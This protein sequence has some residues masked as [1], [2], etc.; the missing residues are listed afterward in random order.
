MLNRLIKVAVLTGTAHLF[1]LYSLKFVSSILLAYQLEFIGE[2]DSITNLIISVIGLGLLMSTVRDIAVSNNWKLDFLKA[3]QSRF[4]LSLFLCPVGFLGIYDSIYFIFFFSPIFAL[5]GDYAFYGRSQPVFAAFLALLKV[6]LPGFALIVSAI[7]YPKHVFLV[8]GFSIIIS[9]LICSIITIRKLRTSFFTKPSISSLRSYQKNL[10]LGIVTLS[11]YFLGLG[12]VLI[13]SFFYDTVVIAKAYLIIKI[14]T[15]FKGVLRM[16]NQ[17]FIKEMTDDESC[18]KVDQL[19]FLSAS[20]FAISL[21][22]FPQ[23]FKYLLLED[24]YFENISSLIYIVLASLVCA[25]FTSYTTKAILEK[26]DKE[27]A[28]WACYSIVI[29][30]L[31]AFICSRISQ[32]TNGLF[33]S[34][35]IGE[36]TFAIGLIVIINKPLGVILRLRGSLMFIPYLLLPLSFRFIFGDQLMTLIAGLG[37]FAFLYLFNRKADFLPKVTTDNA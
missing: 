1:T 35:L 11:F 19:A 29:T 17:S 9:H 16:I 12:L 31:T 10:Q 25:R 32:S 23:T 2:V 20:L 7:Y 37:T 33:I 28:K 6:L 3:Q 27:Y 14:Y 21:F 26:R 5:N 22:L 18:F 36:L 8:F 13:S 34:L 30:I 4:T 15:V 24:T